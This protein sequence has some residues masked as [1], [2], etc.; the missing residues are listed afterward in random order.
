MLFRWRCS[1]TREKIWYG[2]SLPILTLVYVNSKHKEA[3]KKAAPTSLADLADFGAGKGSVGN[4]LIIGGAGGG[5]DRDNT[6]RVGAREPDMRGGV[7]SRH[8]KNRVRS[9]SCGQ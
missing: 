9:A 3:S 8:R 2:N 6:E 5:R 1:S 4:S 7:G